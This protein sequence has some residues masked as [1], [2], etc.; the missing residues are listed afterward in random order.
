MGSEGRTNPT[1]PHYN[2]SMSRRTRRPIINNLKIEPQESLDELKKDGRLIIRS[3][4][5]SI[6]QQK[7]SLKQ[8]IEGRCSLAQHFREEEGSE[9]DMVVRSGDHDHDH[10]QDGFGGVKWK[11][12]MVGNYGRVLRRLIKVKQESYFRAWWKPALSLKL[13]KHK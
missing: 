1:K 12:S 4:K 13:V 2:I 6:T 11:R 3:D 7:F 9:K 8:L 10:D 5:I